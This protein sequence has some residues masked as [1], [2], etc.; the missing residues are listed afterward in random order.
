MREI[1]L[2]SIMSIAPLARSSGTMLAVEMSARIAASQVSHTLIPS[3]WKIS[4]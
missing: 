1:G 4:L 2:E 3:A